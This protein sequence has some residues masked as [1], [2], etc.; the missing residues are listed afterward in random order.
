[1][2]KITSFAQD[3]PGSRKIGIPARLPG[4]IKTLRV[5]SADMSGHSFFYV[6]FTLF[7][8]LHGGYDGGY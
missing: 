1:M 2:D 5:V 6:G 4:Q 3:R 8:S 7:L